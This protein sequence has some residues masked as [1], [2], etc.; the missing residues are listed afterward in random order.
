MLRIFK[1]GI[2]G[3][4]GMFLDFSITF[5]CKEKLY[6]N[7][8]LSNSIG[9]TVAVIFNYLGN[10]YWT[11]NNHTEKSIV[12]FILFFFFSTVGLILNNVAINIL[13]DKLKLKFY[14]SKL[15]A[16]CIVFIWN[17]T[18]NSSFTFN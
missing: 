18:L 17:Y 14:V 9:F 10:K 13:H 6:F 15:A 7:K 16:T 3:I 8:Y 1:Y 2:V 5:I 12:Q 11:F 4:F